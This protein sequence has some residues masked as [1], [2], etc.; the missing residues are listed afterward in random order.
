LKPRL[1]PCRRGRSRNFRYL[2]CQDFSLKTSPIMVISIAIRCGRT[3][4]QLTGRATGSL[5]FHFSRAAKL[6]SSAG[7]TKF[8]APIAQPARPRRYTRYIGQTPFEKEAFRRK[9]PCSFFLSSRARLWKD[10]RLESSIRRKTLSGES[11][12]HRH[13]ACR[14][15]RRHERVGGAPLA[16]SSFPHAR[17]CH[18]ILLQAVGLRT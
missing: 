7:L 1:S 14:A 11:S 13:P 2:R 6:T 8:R 4:R 17:A 9:L 15:L 3:R 16:G 10:S 18:L 5:T 12:H